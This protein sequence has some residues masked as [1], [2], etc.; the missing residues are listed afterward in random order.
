MD[1]RIMSLSVIMTS[2]I[3]S[4]LKFQSHFQFKTSA[5]PIIPH[6]ATLN[7][8]LSHGQEFSVGSG[9][10][11]AGFVLLPL[12]ALQIGSGRQRKRKSVNIDFKL[13]LLF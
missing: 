5:L 8:G 10:C 3:E 1:L 6:Y 11:V 12:L 2:S 7:T 9:V 13:W 4:K